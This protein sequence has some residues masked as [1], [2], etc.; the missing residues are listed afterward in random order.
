MQKNLS[1]ILLIDKPK[2]PS[3]HQIVQKIRAIFNFRKVG[4]AGTLDPLATGLLIIL[5]GSATKK[6][7]QFLKYKKTY[8]LEIEFGKQTDTQDSE[9]K[10]TKSIKNIPKISK[11][12]FNQILKQFCGKFLQKIPKYSAKKINGQRLCDLTRKNENP[13]KVFKKSIEI[14]AIKI[15]KFFWPKVTVEVSCCSGTFMRQLAEDCGEAL[16]IPS[17]AKN[18]K[19]IA[20]GKYTLDRSVKICDIASSKNPEKFIL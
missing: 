20:I 13:N 10:I 1:G 14:Y 5:I 4:H 9:G 12:D 11:N 15:I 7:D 17:Y 2:G 8:L 18:I 6:F 16:K 19:R 3:S